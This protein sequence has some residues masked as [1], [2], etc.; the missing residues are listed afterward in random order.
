M[1]KR[2]KEAQMLAK[3]DGIEFNVKELV[4]DWILVT[5][6][7][8]VTPEGNAI[9]YK[10]LQKA[11]RIGAVMHTRSVYLMPLTKQTEIA[12][13]ELSKGEGKVFVWTSNIT[14]EQ[15]KRELTEL[16]DSRI[17]ADVKMLGERIK[18][19]NQHILVERYGF[20]R[21]M[22]DKTIALFNNALFA[23]AQ[24]GS[25]ELLDKLGQIREVLDELDKQL[26]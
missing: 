21:R 4:E 2:L 16:Y 23:V 1:A 3:F 15:T 13:L 26:A 9:R 24:R 19:I 8:P 12:A 11:P 14:D 7:L 22:L 20:A 18:R 6:D 10:F 5:Y 17:G 25:K